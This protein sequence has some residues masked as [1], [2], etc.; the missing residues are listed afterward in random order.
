MPTHALLCSKP[1][2]GGLY[3]KEE[4]ENSVFPLKHTEV[5]AKITGHLSRVEVTQ[6]FDNPYQE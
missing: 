3:V 6:T 1:L 4:E 2:L 5:Y